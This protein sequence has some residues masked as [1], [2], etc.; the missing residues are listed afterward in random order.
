MIMTMVTMTIRRMTEGVLR[1][2]DFSHLHQRA[3]LALIDDGLLN[4]VLSED[5]DVMMPSGTNTKTTHT[6][7]IK[8]F[9]N[10]STCTVVTVSWFKL[11]FD[12]MSSSA[13]VC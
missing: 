7:E 5:D 3:R 9:S 4:R 2:S 8:R 12:Q 6:I 11:G 13:Q 10:T 1:V